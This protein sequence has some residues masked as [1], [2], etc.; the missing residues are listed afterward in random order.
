MAAI[1]GMFSGIED[2]AADGGN[3]PLLKPGSYLLSV[4]QL[5]SFKSKKPPFNAFFLAEFDILGANGDGCSAEG[6]KA[7][8]LVNMI[9]SPALGNIKAFALA[10]VPGLTEEDITE[11]AMEEMLGET[12]PLNGL[13]VRAEAQV[14]K[15]KSDRDFTKVTFQKVS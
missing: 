5:R 11:E 8:W 15:T 1:R 6:S 4:D 9:H 3:I 12:Q 10:A 13:Q 7:A 2:A 14:V